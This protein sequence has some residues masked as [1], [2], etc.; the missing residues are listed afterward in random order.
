MGLSYMYVVQKSLV[1]YN[2]ETI[3]KIKFITCCLS[4]F[5]S[6]T[7]TNKFSS[8]TRPEKSQSEFCKFID[9]DPCLK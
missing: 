8:P 1:V 2:L 7:Y 3:P 4:S 6:R 9:Y 5:N